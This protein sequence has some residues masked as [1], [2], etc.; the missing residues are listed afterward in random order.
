M[1]LH[2]GRW[3]YAW[4]VV[5]MTFV[6]LLISGGVRAAPGVLIRP[7]EAEFGWGRASISL[8]IG[9]GFLVYGLGGVV[10]G[11][12]I[13]RFGLRGV[14]LGATGLMVLGLAPLVAL[15][16]L[17]Q[18]HLLWGVVVGLG[19]G[20][21]ASVLGAAVAHRWF[22]THHGLVVG[23]LGAATSGGQVLFVPILMAAI[24]LIGWRG[25]IGLLAVASAA[26]LLPL[27]LVM[28]DRPADVGLRPVGEEAGDAPSAVEDAER[29]PLGR[30]IRNRDFWLLAGTFFICGYTA[31]GLVGTHLIPHAVEHGFSEA[32][33]ANT[34]ALMGGINVVGT[35]TSGW[36]TD[37]FD[38]RKLLATYYG[39]RALSIAA[40]PFIVDVRG[41]VLFAMVCGLDWAATL[42]P[43]TNLTARLF[44]RGSLGTLFG[45][46]ILVHMVGA[47]AAAYS[48]GF[49]RE[50]MGD[51]HYVF[52]FAALLGF[53]AVG[54][55]LSI[56]NPASSTVPRPVVLRTELP[57][58]A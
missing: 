44:G 50:V 19:T 25:G 20:G 28:R 32:V 58:A 51:Y 30:A 17:W 15:R 6:T 46:I 54:M 42:P 49:F 31:N 9:V 35:L 52:L 5:A 34:L 2:G 45:W 43:T 18:L 10:S 56:K 40:L 26:L 55:S 13:D 16:E 37:R 14:T 1:W 48:G 29:T 41:M 4:I 38:N 11:S 3:H 24:G 47:A 27:A 53:V 33:A 39:F 7:L 8:A 22:R 12:L 57:R 23:L 21:T 36:L